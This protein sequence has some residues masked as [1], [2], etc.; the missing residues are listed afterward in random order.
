LN[1]K[2]T[3]LRDIEIDVLAELM[4]N[5]RKSDRELAKALGIS[6]PTVTRMRTKLEKS[7]VIKEYTLIPDFKQLG[8]QI[9]A[10]VFMGKQE[11]QDRKYRIELRKAATELEAKTPQASLTIVDGMGLGKGRMLIFLYKDYASYMEGLKTIRS[12]AHVD[13]EDMETFLVDLNDESLFRILTL[14]EIARHLQTFGK[15]S[16]PEKSHNP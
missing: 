3:K 6:Q 14:K 16:E 1:G 4:K 12:L 7:G 8:Y 10:V 9:M 15:S 5:S 2:K 11:P 13:A